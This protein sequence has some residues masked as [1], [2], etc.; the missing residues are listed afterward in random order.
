VNLTLLLCDYC[1]EVEEIQV[2]GTYK[3]VIRTKTLNGR[4]TEKGIVFENSLYKKTTKVYLFVSENP[5]DYYD[6][7]P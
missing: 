2:N 6:N 3:K 5:G 1:V 7:Q 4:I